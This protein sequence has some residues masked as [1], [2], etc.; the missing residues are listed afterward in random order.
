MNF[1]FFFSDSPESFTD[2]CESTKQSISELCG[3]CHLQIA[4]V[5]ES[6]PRPPLPEDIRGQVV[7]FM[8]SLPVLQQCQENV[9]KLLS[10]ML[11][12]QR[13]AGVGVYALL[14]ICLFWGFVSWRGPV[15]FSSLDTVGGIAW[16]ER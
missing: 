3:R 15:F 6:L 8:L 16:R 9:C 14:V 1:L 11:A 10:L 2:Q 12:A 4:D 13:Y 7:L 5:D